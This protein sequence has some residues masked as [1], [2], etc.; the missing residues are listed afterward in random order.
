MIDINKA[1]KTFNNYIKSYD[2]NDL[3]TKWKVI[4]TFRVVE[5][6]EILAQKL[7]LNE[8]QTEL[9]KLIGLLHDI[10]RFEEAKILKDFNSNQFDHGKY[11]ITLL[12]E[13]NMIRDFIETDKYDEII[14]FA[15]ANH[16]QYAIEDTKDEEKLFFAKLIRDADKLDIIRNKVEAPLLISSNKYIREDMEVSTISKEVHEL[17]FEK[18]TIVSGLNK[19]L[20]DDWVRIM[21][22]IYDIN[23]DISFEI[24]YEK[25][26]FEALI[27]KIDYKNIDTKKQMGLM[28]DYGNKYIRSKIKL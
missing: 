5:V 12:F 1:I 22:F 15:V 19:T 13:N 8:E 14:K 24:L 27:D 11:A 25:N 28:K 7:N 16:N 21:A 2:M 9:I 4:H 18:K 3:K 23:F 20:L 10:G 26:Y 6:C 17:F